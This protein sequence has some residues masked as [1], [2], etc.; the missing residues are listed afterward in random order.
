M[1]KDPLDLL[2]ESNNNLN[3]FDRL[4]IN[5]CDDLKLLC[6]TELKESCIITDEDYNI[7]SQGYAGV[8]G[9]VLLTSILNAI[10]H[11]TKSPKELKHHSLF[12]IAD[13]RPL[14]Q[15]ECVLVKRLGIS[16]VITREMDK[17]NRDYFSLNS[18]KVIEE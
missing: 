14:S 6:K 12:Y 4:I 9:G 13:G 8:C 5:Y 15:E 11:C 17:V 18:I 3:K 10:M 16:R 7:V 1:D 2:S